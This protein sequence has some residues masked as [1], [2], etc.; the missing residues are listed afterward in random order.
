M[1]LVNDALKRA[2]QAQP[3]AAPPP[4]LPA[5]RPDFSPR[6][7]QGNRF[8]LPALVG[9][10]F[11]MGVLL[12]WQWSRSGNAPT[13]VRARTIPETAQSSP[14][15]AIAPIPPIAPTTP[16]S[17]P[18]PVPPAPATKIAAAPA[19]VA[20]PAPPPVPTYKLQSIFYTRK[21]PSAVIN[22]KLLQIGDRIGEARV[23]LIE[24]DAVTVVTLKGETKVL[25][26]P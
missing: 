2:K 21:N 20:A 16:V 11:L 15:P 9:V 25:E 14:P 12:L 13:P 19:P 5:M 8:V 18:P 6:P 1:S 4:D 24:K 22:G 26:L 10:I 23:K 3:N 7:K 17:T